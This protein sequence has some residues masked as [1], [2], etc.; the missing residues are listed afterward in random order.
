MIAENN[1]VP[2]TIKSP[3]RYPGGKYRAVETVAAYIPPTITEL[4][5]P[6]FGGGS[7]ELYLAS[8]GVQVYGYDV[9]E[10]LVEFWQYVL[11]DAPALGK[12][13]E[14]YYPLKNKYHFYELKEAQRKLSTPLER[15]AVFYVLNRC[16]FSGSTLSGG[17]SPNHP[18][19]TRRVIQKLKRF[20]NPLIQVQLADFK[21]SLSNHPNTFA[22]LDPPYLVKVPLYGRN[23]NAHR[24]FDHQE[25]ADLLRKR[26]QWLLSYNDC[27][28][29][30]ELY[31]DYHI[32]TPEWKYGMTSSRKSNEVLIFSPDLNPAEYVA[33]TK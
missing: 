12:E 5:S 6:F 7:I 25:L 18:R 27:P 32:I 28:E 14:K 22:Y 26:Q 13:V 29:I 3:L 23:G 2:I 33:T 8:K 15:A 17:M 11:L 1:A 4:V 24:F 30:R 20:Y 9:F 21:A 31:K 19:F 16:S 10:P